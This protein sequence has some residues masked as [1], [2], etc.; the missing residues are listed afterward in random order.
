MRVV[1]ENPVE[2]AKETV[3]PAPM[4]APYDWGW[5]SWLVVGCAVF[6]AMSVALNLWY[7]FGPGS[8]EPRLICRQP[9]V[10]VGPIPVDG[11]A[12]VVFVLENTGGADVAIEKVIPSC[13]CLFKPPNGAVVPPGHEIRLPV[14]VKMEKQIGPLTKTLV[15]RSNSPREPNLLLT[16]R[17]EGVSDPISGREQ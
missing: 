13:R 7:W 10:N 8:W 3:R 5:R 4:F 2:S 6:C 15:V 1:A 9:V 12:E 14:Q 11:S 17:G 16:I